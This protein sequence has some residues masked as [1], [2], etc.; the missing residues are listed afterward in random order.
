MEDNGIGREVSVQNKSSEVISDHNSKG[1]R[2]TQ[3]RLK[4]SN[5]LNQ[6]NA[7]VETF[8]KTTSMGEAEGTRV[9]LVFNE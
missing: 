4:L 6:R 7:T 8:D 1:V 5:S 3:T 2:L 9:I